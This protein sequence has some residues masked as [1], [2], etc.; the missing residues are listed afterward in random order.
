MRVPSLGPQLSGFL[1]CL[2]WKVTVASL[3]EILACTNL[4]FTA[5]FWVSK[6]E[7]LINFREAV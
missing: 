7:P 6:S 3:R 5:P 1:A 4:L 2:V